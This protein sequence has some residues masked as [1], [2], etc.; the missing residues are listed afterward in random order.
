MTKQT[1]RILFYSAVVIFVLLSYVV[2]LYAQGY[3]YS[4]SEAKFFRTGSIFVKANEDAKVYLNDKFLNSTSFFGNSYTI[5]GLL[6]RQYTVRLQKDNFSSWQKK[7]S[8]EEGLVNDYS[9]ILLLPKSGD[10]DIPLK[11]EIID[12]LYPIPK[13]TLDSKNSPQATPSPLVKPTPKQSLK[14]SPTQT[15]TPPP[16]GG[17][18]EPFYLKNGVLFKNMENGETERL[19]YLV[20]GFVVSSDGKKITWWNENELWV[21]WVSDTDYQPYHKAGDKDL[22]TKFSVKIKNAAWFR[23]ND[24]IVVDSAGYKVLEIDKRGG[25]NVVEVN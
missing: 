22:I 21:M 10:E 13:P 4:F 2:I 11:Q 9:R 1:K 14:S 15:P 19:A 18:T 7:V 6:P 20:A 8:V 3:K 12:L 23:D 17:S 25:L 5:S 24:H 16:V